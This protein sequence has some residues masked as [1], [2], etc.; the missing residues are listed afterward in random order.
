MA[1]EK[2]GYVDCIGKCGIRLDNTNLCFEYGV[3]AYCLMTIHNDSYLLTSIDI[4]YIHLF[5]SCR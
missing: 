3:N 1:I 5:D 2:D 4:S